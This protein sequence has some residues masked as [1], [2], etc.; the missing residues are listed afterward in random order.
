MATFNNTY[1]P[2]PM[3]ASV[4]H[5]LSH[6]VEGADE[7]MDIHTITLVLNGQS[8]EFDLVVEATDMDTMEEHRWEGMAHRYG[9]VSGFKEV[10]V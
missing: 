9:G 5:A 3:L 7:E 10:T 1:G 8:G 2:E 4:A 6:D